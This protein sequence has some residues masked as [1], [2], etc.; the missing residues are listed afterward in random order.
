MHSPQRCLPHTT[1]T[2]PAHSP[3]AP[4]VGGIALLTLLV[5]AT[6]TGP[7][8]QAL[9]LTKETMAKMELRLAALRQLDAHTQSELVNIGKDKKYG[10]IVPS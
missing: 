1:T 5:N 3:L 6:M 4:P 2:Q 9:G 7:L 10:S 8:L